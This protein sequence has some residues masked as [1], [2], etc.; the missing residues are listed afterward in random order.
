MNEFIGIDEL[1]SPDYDLMEDVAYKGNLFTGTA[2]ENSNNSHTEWHFLNG[3]AHGRWFSVSDSGQLLED[4][5]Y[6][7]GKKITEKMWNSLGILCW[8]YQREP[9]LFQEFY[10]DG[11]LKV[12]RDVNSRKIYYST[13]QIKQLFDYSQNYAM[14]YYKDGTWLFKHL[15]DGEQHLVMSSE[16]ITFHDEFLCKVYME[17]LEEDFDYFYPYFVLWIGK[18]SADE[19][20]SFICNLITS[21]NLWMKNAGI[22][23]AETYKLRQAVDLLEKERNNQIIPP[24]HQGH[25]YSYSIGQRARMVLGTLKQKELWKNITDHL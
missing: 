10:Y 8:N 7:N 5:F 25:Y 1:E 20:A 23:L 21:E 2:I 9:L 15:S 12:Q 18:V 3:K 17:L 22:N 4:A 13:G 14:S 24:P 19:R 6:E 11:T 16:K